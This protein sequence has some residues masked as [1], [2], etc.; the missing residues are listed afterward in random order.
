MSLLQLLEG[1]VSSGQKQHVPDKLRLEYP[2]LDYN[3][4]LNG[5]DRI[6]LERNLEDIRLDGLY[7]TGR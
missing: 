3:N 6:R 2:V 1:L 4:I 7:K 5:P